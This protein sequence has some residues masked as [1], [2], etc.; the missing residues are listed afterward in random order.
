MVL[1]LAQCLGVH[2]LLGRFGARHELHLALAGYLYQNAVHLVS[3]LGQF[4]SR[5]QV[6]GLVGLAAQLRA[7]EVWHWL[8]VHIRAGWW[9][10]ILNPLTLDEDDI[11]TMSINAYRALVFIAVFG[12]GDGLWSEVNECAIGRDQ[13]EHL[14]RGLA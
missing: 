10:D 3:A 6:V 11:R 8:V 13:S 9:R 14:V 2:R 1:D 4:P 7:A 12:S 5:A